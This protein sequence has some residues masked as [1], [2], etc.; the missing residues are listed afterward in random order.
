MLDLKGHAGFALAI[1]DTSIEASRL[2][3]F[4]HLND[5]KLIRINRNYG[6][7]D[8]YIPCGSVE[9][10]ESILGKKIVPDYYPEW[11]Q[12][13]LHRKV[14]KADK[15]PLEKVFIKPSERYKRFT[16]F[17]TTG[18]YKGKKKPP[19]WCSEIIHFQNEWRYYISNG[20]V[21][22]SGWYSGDEVNTPDAPE[23]NIEIPP[24][25]CGAVDFGWMQKFNNWGDYFSLIEVNH[26]YACGWYGPR[27]QDHLYFEWLA[28]GWEYMK[29]NYATIK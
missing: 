16:G 9:W 27:E 25:F 3:M 13:Y 22:C 1:G 26:P 23:L 18:T 24:D 14:W 20:K 6:L 5:I 4:C 21:L 11:L 10:C 17:V 2:T 19:Y 15:W 8:N 7:E 12:D 29:K 28:S